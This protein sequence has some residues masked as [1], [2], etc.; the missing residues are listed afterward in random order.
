MSRPVPPPCGTAAA[1]LAAALGLAACGTAGGGSGGAPTAA[2]T[3]DG[4]S[5]APRLVQPGSPGEPTRTVTTD[6][7]SFDAPRHTAADVAFMQGMIVHHAQALTMSALVPDRTGSADIALLA[8]RIAI[9]QRDEIRLMQGW[10]RERDESAPAVATGA[11]AGSEEAHD[12]E[13][14][15][16]MLTDEQMARLVDAEGD[17]FDRLFL[18]SMIMHHEG[19]IV[20]VENLFRTPGAAQEEEVF[21]FASH[22]DADQR[23]EIARMSRML[24]AMRGGG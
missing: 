5:A 4:G 12:H 20:M 8:E 18:A 2:P 9:S 1:L 22:V 23:S 21:T 16:G 24:S 14:M 3:P 15:P 17:A 11:V 10:L 13:L 19:A 6:E 7:A